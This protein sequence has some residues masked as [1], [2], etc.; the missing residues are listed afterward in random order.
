MCSTMYHLQMENHCT[1]EYNLKRSRFRLERQWNCSSRCNHI[2]CVMQI[3]NIEDAVNGKKRDWGKKAHSCIDTPGSI[4]NLQLA[5]KGER[6]GPPI[7]IAMLQI[8]SCFAKQNC[9]LRSPGGSHSLLNSLTRGKRLC[10]LRSSELNLNRLV[11][12]L[13]YPNVQLEGRKAMVSSP[14][15]HSHIGIT[16]FPIHPVLDRLDRRYPSSRGCP[17]SSH[18][19]LVNLLVYS[20]Q[21]KRVL[22]S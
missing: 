11:I 18:D 2:I 13:R 15:T 9:Q 19:R 12:V 10:L 21:V 22:R 8:L 6:G 7:A 3:K 4:Y 1:W 20:R 5:R 17:I 14:H 16:E